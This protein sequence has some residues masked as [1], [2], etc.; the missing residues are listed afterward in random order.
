LDKLIED[1]TNKFLD[2]EQKLEK[3]YKESIKRLESKK[4]NTISEE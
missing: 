1:K 4:K 3:V 2:R